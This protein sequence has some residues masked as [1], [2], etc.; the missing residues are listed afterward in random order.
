M[1][2]EV[3]VPSLKKRDSKPPKAISILTLWSGSGGFD[4]EGEYDFDFQYDGV[5]DLLKL[6]GILKGVKDGP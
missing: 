6:S 2:A 5:I 1:F 3:P 4:W